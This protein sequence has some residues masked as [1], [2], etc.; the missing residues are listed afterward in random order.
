MTT[1]RGEI[2]RTER[3]SDR[4]VLGSG[5]GLA[6]P[7][8]DC[9]PGSMRDC[10]KNARPG[11]RPRAVLVIADT[12]S[13]GAPVP[14]ARKCLR[15][16]SRSVSAASDFVYSLRI[17]VLLSEAAKRRENNGGEGAGGKKL[18]A[19][20]GSCQRRNVAVPRL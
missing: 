1:A 6:I 20:I 15:S 18:N 17:N 7:A 12:C 16:M 13:A 8:A 14:R 10:R 5:A 11:E 9:R 2:R 19:T 3:E 4:T